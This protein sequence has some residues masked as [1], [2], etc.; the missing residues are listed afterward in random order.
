MSCQSVDQWNSIHVNFPCS[1]PPFPSEADILIFK[2]WRRIQSQILQV[3]VFFWPHS[4]CWA[5]NTILVVGVLSGLWVQ[6]KTRMLSS[7]S[8]SPATPA[9]SFLLV[10]PVSKASC[11]LCSLVRQPVPFHIVSTLTLET[12]SQSLHVKRDYVAA[13]S[14]YKEVGGE[15]LRE[16]VFNMQKGPKY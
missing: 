8:S 11:W 2:N 7:A 1:P 14:T 12:A 3:L 6:V 13:G 15:C 16:T 4:T 10:Y 9:N 5:G